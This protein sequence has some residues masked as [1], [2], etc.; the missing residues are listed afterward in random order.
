[1]TF[2]RS[3]ISTPF[4][5]WEFLIHTLV[6]EINRI[7]PAA[8]VDRLDKLAT[9]CLWLSLSHTFLCL[10]STTWHYP[11]IASAAKQ[12]KRRKP[13]R[14]DGPQDDDYEY[15]SVSIPCLVGYGELEQCCK[16]CGLKGLSIE[17]QEFILYQIV[18]RLGPRNTQSL[19]GRLVKQGYITSWEDDF[20]VEEIL[21]HVKDDEE[22]KIYYLIKWY[23]WSSFYNTWE[24]EGN[25]SC[26]DLLKEY[27]I[28]NAKGISRKRGR[29]KP[30]ALPPQDRKQHIMEELYEKFLDS[31]I[32]DKMSL[33]DLVKCS[34]PQNKI[35][36]FNSTRPRQLVR[37]KK[38]SIKQTKSEIQTA[39][40]AWEKR[41]N[42][43]RIG[44]DPAPIF[45]ENKVD[46]EGP[47]ENFIFINERRAGP[48]VVIDKDP[49]VGCCCEDCYVDRKSCCAVASGSEPPYYKTNKRLRLD[50]GVP[51]YECNSRCQCGPDCLNRVVQK[52]RKVKICIFRTA[53]K[54]WGVKALQPIKKGSFV[55]EY[56][57]EVITNEEAEKRGKTYDASGMT[58]LFDLDF[59]DS[60][61]PFA[62][63]A[64][65]YGN[66]SHFINHSC[67]PNL[68]VHVAWINTLDPHL[69]HICLFAKRDISRNEE[70][71]F[72]YN[73]GKSIDGEL[74]TSNQTSDSLQDK[75]GETSS[76]QLEPLEGPK[77]NDIFVAPKGTVGARNTTTLEEFLS[78]SK[79]P[80]PPASDIESSAAEKENSIF[81]MACLC[82]AK[83]CRKFLFF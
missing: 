12:A 20:E 48:G 74:N 43:M 23:G 80:T 9:S 70:L 82:G 76:T 60:D 78:I 14:R 22:D 10:T 47:P 35:F 37:V 13:S 28:L 64:G 27:Q 63:D 41:L 17:T 72:D 18:K 66:A 45:V 69:P 46:L 54:G 31:G 50:R 42:E 71:T 58:Y 7:C 2:Q 44:Y 11:H 55:I 53:T 34:D 32:L 33:K 49:L 51:I 24:P 68:E 79:V 3:S 81:T 15:S 61:G 77:D 4:H 52:G 26:F 25:L 29:P 56:V 59:N 57:G 6:I 1:M 30:A 36:K 73:C 40:R 19:I 21:D 75:N 83:N 67:D 8:Y 16:D 5:N 39:L 38:S 65:T 62:V